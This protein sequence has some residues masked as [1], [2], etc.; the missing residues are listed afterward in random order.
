M[1]SRLR[2]APHLR[3]PSAARLCPAGRSRSASAAQRPSP[4]R[5]PWSSWSSRFFSPSLG[6]EGHGSSPKISD[7]TTCANIP[8]YQGII[9]VTV[10]DN[11]E[12]GT[13]ALVRMVK[14]R[15]TCTHHVSCAASPVLH[16]PV[17][18]RPCPPQFQ[19]LRSF[20]Q[21]A[22]I[23]QVCGRSPSPMLTALPSA[24]MLATASP[25]VSCAC[26]CITFNTSCRYSGPCSTHLLAAAS[27]RACRLSI[28][29]ARAGA[30]SGVRASLT[31]SMLLRV[32]QVSTIAS[33]KDASQFDS[34]S[35]AIENSFTSDFMYMPLS[36]SATPHTDAPFALGARLC[37]RS[38]NS[39]CCAGRRVRH[40]RD[41][42]AT[43]SW[44]RPRATPSR[45]PRGWTPPARPTRQTKPAWSGSLWKTN[46]VLISNA[47][48][49][50][51]VI[52]RVQYNAM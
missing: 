29:G 33:A 48:T 51:E 30:R 10:T 45:P 22:Q 26:L 27:C 2:A 5:R 35:L 52:I 6:N 24:P 41:A 23:D 39:F 37:A 47:I 1:C 32:P 17:C 13:Q 3:R 38:A 20:S 18:A 9:C 28:W 7:V 19:D 4:A 50:A 36:L 25:G 43:A 12:I 42:G 15:M 21:L 16:S 44:W 40:C 46:T 34:Y 49:A 11:P 8:V 31:P 14:L